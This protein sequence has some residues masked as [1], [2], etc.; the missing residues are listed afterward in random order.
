MFP[1]HLKKLAKI[2]IK[3]WHQILKRAYQMIVFIQMSW[4]TPHQDKI[5]LDLTIGEDDLGQLPKRCSL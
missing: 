3:S 4:V 1:F 2:K 5:A